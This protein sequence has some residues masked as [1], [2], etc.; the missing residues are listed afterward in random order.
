MAPGLGREEACG[1]T[2]WSRLEKN[3]SQGCL[4]AA[5]GGA[6]VRGARVRVL[7]VPVSGPSAPSLRV[8]V[9]PPCFH[10]APYLLL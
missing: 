6:G 10:L 2:G 5:A 7:G 3:Q 8:L 4:A 9:A 1:Q